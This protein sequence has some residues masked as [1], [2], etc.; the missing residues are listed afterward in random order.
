MPTEQSP[1]PVTML[2]PNL[3]LKKL[4]EKR[5]VFGSLAQ[6]GSEETCELQAAAGLDFV[7]VDLE[8]GA[9][10]VEGAIAMIRAIEA[11]GALALV[12]VDAQDRLAI[13]KVLD[14]G[15]HGIVLPSIDN[16]AQLQ[17][18]V[19][20]TRF[21]P[22][23]TRG[24]CPTVRASFHGIHDWDEYAAW[25]A[26]NIMVIALIETREGVENFPEIVE[27]D[28]LSAVGFG[29]FDLAVAF[30]HKDREAD[31]IVE[32]R[33]RMSRVALDKGLEVLGM[34]P[35]TTPEATLS[36]I[37]ARAETGARILLFGSDRAVMSDRYKLA[38]AAARRHGSRA[39][40]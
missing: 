37:Q 34:V 11:A 31:D 4:R 20:A 39:A 1:T 35:I 27:V 33:K 3:I 36:A 16:A 5:A 21:R 14:A 19:A 9:F 7:L 10:G 24:A 12:R 29:G 23:G 32:M 30:G 13:N 40:S 25:A 8:H 15:A 2:K 38:M 17:E 26:S 6:I 28:G 18:V 22:R